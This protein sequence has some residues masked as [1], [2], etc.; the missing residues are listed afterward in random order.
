MNIIDHGCGVVEFENVIN[1]DK[2]FLKEYI[3]YISLINESTFTYIE[4][5]GKKYALNKTGF[6]F[7][8]QDI[9]EAPS[10]YTKLYEDN[11]DKKY[12]LFIDQINQGLYQC[13]VEYCKLYPDA[14]TTI[15]WKIDGHIAGYDFGQWIGPHCDDQIPFTFGETPN[16]EFPI[17]NTVSCGLYLN[18][19][20]DLDSVDEFTY[21][22]G[23][24]NFPHAKVTYKPKSGGVIMY[25]SNYIGRHEVKPVTKGNRYVFLQFYSYGVPKNSSLESFQ[26]LENLKK[27]AQ[28]S[29]V[30][31]RQSDV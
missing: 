25:P 14:H 29:H 9:P 5:D 18:D 21:S 4:E 8:V 15:W 10:R 11:A 24:M 12:I 19:C 13:L 20:V 22:G 27:D 16:N 2:T 28:A 23:E 7:E 17:H 6:K 30:I 31:Q 26:M 3:N 1:I